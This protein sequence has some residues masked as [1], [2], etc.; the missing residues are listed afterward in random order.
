MNVSVG[1][2]SAAKLVCY[3]MSD[4]CSDIVKKKGISTAI[5]CSKWQCLTK[6]LIQKPTEKLAELKYSSRIKPFLSSRSGKPAAD[7]NAI[8]FSV[9]LTAGT[10]TYCNL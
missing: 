5:S 10:S 7:L 2:N 1:E 3:F 9:D 8:S 6:H 4:H